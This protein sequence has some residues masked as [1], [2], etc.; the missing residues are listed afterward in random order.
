MKSV[1]MF[2]GQG[3]QYLGM[4]EDLYNNYQE[5]KEVFDQADQILGYS[6]KDIMFNNEE[7]LNNTLYTQVAMFTLYVAIIEVLKSK[8]IKTDYAIGLSL[9]EYGAL[10]YNDVFDFETGLRIL[11]KRGLFMNEA[12]SKTKGLMSAILGME[13]SVLEEII[14]SVDGYVKIA[15]YN[16]YGQLV[17]S[18][19]ENS[20]LKVNELALEKGA[21]RAIV[22]NTSGPFHTKLMNEAAVMFDEY[23]SSVEL[24]E[25]R[26]KLLVNTT[27]DYYES[28]LK[29]T[30][31]SQITSSV[32]F[33]QMI[34][35]LIDDGVT[36]F[37]E[38]GPK[39]S[40]CGF[41]KKI[42]RKLDIYN[43]EDTTSLDKLLN[44][45]KEE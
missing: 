17:I 4:G 26:G 8:D 31:V 16:T 32:M 45:L 11:E 10:Y 25:P 27:G 39:K 24:G 41:V 34:E 42:N 12:A 13:A 2:S 43:V 37:I 35:K 6:I 28:N 7:M 15:N 18:G 3:S 19:Q 44:F 29:D 20:V 5:A 33:Y 30:M 9:G 1:L 14:S 40:L 36:T 22:L 38:V 21:K 23:L